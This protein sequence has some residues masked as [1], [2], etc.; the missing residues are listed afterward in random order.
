MRGSIVR[1]ES[2]QIAS[3]LTG[4]VEQ[5]AGEVVRKTGRGRAHLRALWNNHGCAL[6]PRLAIVE[7][8]EAARAE[9]LLLEQSIANPAKVGAKLNRMIAENLGPGVGKVNIGF[10][11]DPG[12]ACRKANQRI[13]KPPVNR[14]THDPAGYLIEVNAGNTEGFRSSRAEIGVVSLVMVPPG[15]HA[16]LRNQSIREKAIVVETGAIRVLKPGPFKIALG[17]S[18]C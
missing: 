10:R 9:R 8:I 1:E 11:P 12:Q 7:R 2:G 13:G 4:H 15:T 18:A 14:N 6:E 3:R 16:E 17:W 5:K